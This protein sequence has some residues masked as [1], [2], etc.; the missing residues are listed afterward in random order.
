MYEKLK[1]MYHRNLLTVE[2]LRNAVA[3]HWI[4]EEQFNEI[5]NGEK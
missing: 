1:N 5:V 2:Q 4:T 3:K